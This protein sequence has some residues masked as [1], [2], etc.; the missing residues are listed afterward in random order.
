MNKSHCT[1]LITM[2]FLYSN[3][4]LAVVITFNGTA[5]SN[6]P[7]S[8]TTYSESGFT[9]TNIGG[10]NFFLDKSFSNFDSDLALFD[11]DVLEWDGGTDGPSAG[12]VLTQISG[13]PFEA[14]SGFVGAINSLG[15]LTFTGNLVGG[16]QV[17]QVVNPSALGVRESFSLVGFT[18]LAS[19]QIG[20]N[21][22]GFPFI[23]DFVLNGD[24]IVPD[25]DPVP[26]P[27][28]FLAVIIGFLTFFRL[29]AKK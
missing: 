15:S 25:P 20:R 2:I 27:S 6:S 29:S 19:L 11:D 17:T 26:E 22:S 3:L 21:G 14:N 12:I 7:I 1:L 4:S 24:P 13:N 28:S 8:V 16:G 23:D 9:F 5:L 18:N 10:N